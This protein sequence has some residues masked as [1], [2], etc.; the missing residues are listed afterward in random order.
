MPPKLIDSLLG[1]EYCHLLN[2]IQILKC[3]PLLLKLKC[4]TV[5]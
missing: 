3:E 2:Y 1:F 4:K 5:S